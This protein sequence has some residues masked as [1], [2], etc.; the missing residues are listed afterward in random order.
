MTSGRPLISIVTPVYNGERFLPEC[1][2]SA[3]NQTY[4]N[5]EMLIAD[6][7]SPDDTRLVIA[8]W[9]QRDPRIRLISLPVNSGPAQARNAAL[10]E[11][12]GRWIAFLDSDD[13]WLPEKLARSLE[14]AQRHGAALHHLGGKVVAIYLKAG[15]THEQVA[16]TNFS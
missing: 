3:L 14:F 4:Q 9:A 13:L 1:I 12:K 5:W 6:Y 2:E 7:C 15:H 11:A 16:R 8:N 10:A